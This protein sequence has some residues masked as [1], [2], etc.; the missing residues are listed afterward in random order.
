MNIYSRGKKSEF[1]IGIILRAHEICLLF[2]EKIWRFSDLTWNVRRAQFYYLKMRMT[3]GGS[4]RKSRIISVEYRYNCRE[5]ISSMMKISKLCDVSR[6]ILK[7][8][9]STRK[10]RKS[11][12]NEKCRMLKAA[13]RE[14]KWK[15]GKVSYGNKSYFIIQFIFSS[16]HW[17]FCS[18]LS[19][20]LAFSP[21]KTQN[22][23]RWQKKKC[24][25]FF[26]SVQHFAL[27]NFHG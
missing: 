13:R 10:S 21:L 24:Y 25:I 22:H 17:L 12:D 2:I 14:R 16:S 5:W 27:F 18:S 26:T 3:T 6:D 1:E 20:L 4:Q 7:R 11:N 19:S 8:A 9:R 23:D 15:C